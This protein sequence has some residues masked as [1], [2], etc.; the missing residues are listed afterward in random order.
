M[1]Y[2]FP[3]RWGA[4]PKPTLNFRRR[5]PRV[6]VFVIH[7][8]ERQ[9]GKLYFLFT[10]MP[11]QNQLG[12]LVNQLGNMPCV[13]GGSI[14]VEPYFHFVTVEWDPFG[15]SRDPRHIIEE[16][17]TYVFMTLLD[18]VDPSFR[19]LDILYSDLKMTIRQ[20]GRQNDMDWAS[21]LGMQM[22]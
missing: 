21:E 14:E 10:E 5:S 16:I 20:L 6:D 18:D 7:H 2:F 3:I 1:W 17:R 9:G 12:A 22:S 11:P 13:V 4:L 15:T 19:A 8:P